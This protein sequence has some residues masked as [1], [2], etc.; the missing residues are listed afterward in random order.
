MLTPSPNSAEIQSRHFLREA[1]AT[2]TSESAHGVIP[3][4]DPPS[5][6]RARFLAPAAPLSAAVGA[7]SSPAMGN[8]SSCGVSRAITLSMAAFRAV[9][10]GDLK[11]SVGNSRQSG[12]QEHPDSPTPSRP[13]RYEKHGSFWAICID[14]RIGTA[15]D[16]AE[17]RDPSPCG[18]R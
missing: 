14:C 11:Q 18:A 12:P 15:W 9:S 3:P 17:R 7:F 4:L 8:M 13:H 6:G 16:S 5:P 2:S 1:F 10:P